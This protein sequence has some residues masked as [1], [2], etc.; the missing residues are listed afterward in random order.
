[1]KIEG[2]KIGNSKKEQVEIN[3]SVFLKSVEIGRWN[4]IPVITVKPS[5]FWN[6]EIRT[7]IGKSA[8]RKAAEKWFPFQMS[9][10]VYKFK[11]IGYDDNGKSIKEKNENFN[12][13]VKSGG[14]VIRKH[15]VTFCRVPLEY[16]RKIHKIERAAV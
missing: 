16:T 4:Y 6:S 15:G 12:E 5:I 11:H 8:T 1:M 14:K 3:G 9:I 10:D 13:A 7:E 2:K